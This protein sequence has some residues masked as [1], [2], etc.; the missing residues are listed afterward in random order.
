MPI[1]QQSETKLRQFEKLRG[2]DPNA[3]EAADRW[4]YDEEETPE[5]VDHTLRSVGTWLLAV[6]P[7]LVALVGIV[8][9]VMT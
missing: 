4:R 7:V 1:I 2:Y 3:R 5:D 8:L 6:V 9:A